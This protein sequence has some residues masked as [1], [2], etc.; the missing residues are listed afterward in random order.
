M[1]H[2]IYHQ[3]FSSLLPPR[4]PNRWD[5]VAAIFSFL[6]SLRPR[7]GVRPCLIQI[8]GSRRRIAASNPFLSFTKVLED[9]HLKGFYLHIYTPYV[10]AREVSCNRAPFTWKGILFSQQNPESPGMMH[11][12]T[13]FHDSPTRSDML[14]ARAIGYP[15]RARSS[16]S[17]LR[18][19]G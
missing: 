18:S 6:S 3:D 11:L 7:T 8:A 15:G 16:S 14:V 12:P 13:V 1:L 2:S 9:Q 4:F 5:Q 17:G 19:A 10:C